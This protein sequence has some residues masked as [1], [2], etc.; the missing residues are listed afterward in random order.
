VSFISSLSF[1]AKVI[2]HTLYGSVNTIHG[3]LF[4]FFLNE[5]LIEEFLM[6]IVDNVVKATKK[7]A[8]YQGWENYETWLVALWIDN[9]KGSQDF[10]RERAA[11][12]SSDADL[13]DEL[14][15]EFEDNM[16]DFGGHGVYQDL[17]QAALGAV[18]WRG[19]AKNLREIE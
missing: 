19:I 13:A 8:E 7:V 9:E 14:K 17:L 12:T 11:E 5:T 4:I 6:N 15:A 1:R 16:P 2:L 18:D 10:W 3:R